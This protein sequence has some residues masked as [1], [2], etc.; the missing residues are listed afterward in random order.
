MSV[1]ALVHLAIAACIAGPLLYAATSKLIDPSRFAAAIPRFGLGLRK[2]SPRAGRLV[3]LIE[4]AAGTAIV[5]VP[6]SLSAVVVVLLYAVFVC[7]LARALAIGSHGDCGCFGA[8]PGGIDLRA[9]A[10]NAALLV[11]S[12]ALVYVRLN[13]LLPAYD[14]RTA[15]LVVVAITLGSAATDTILEVRQRPT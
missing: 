8:L 3:G 10:R 1:L 2:P 5:V 4:L 15:A 13:E 14:Q 11:M 12:F 6:L 7:V 9:V